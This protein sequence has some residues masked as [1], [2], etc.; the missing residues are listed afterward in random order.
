MSFWKRLFERS[1]TVLEEDLSREMALQL[2]SLTQ[3]VSDMDTKGRSQADDLQREFK[4]LRDGVRSCLERMDT[5]DLRWG[6]LREECLDYL[7]RGEKKREIANGER[8]RGRTKVTTADD[9][10]EIKQAVASL[11]A[12]S[13]EA[14]PGAGP[15]TDIM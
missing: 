13:G 2:A 7:E 10:A 4:E 15:G 12:Q 3:C 14:T 9:I 1:A 11:T 5:L 8:S 6:G